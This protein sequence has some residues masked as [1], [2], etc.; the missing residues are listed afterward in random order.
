MTPWWRDAV[1]Y[2]IS[3]RSFAEARRAKLALMRH[4]VLLRGINVGAHNRIAMP[5][6]RELLERAG[7]DEVQTYLQSGNVVLSSSATG[8]Q[9]A[10]TCER[11]IAD[12]LGL[13]I[14]VVVRTRAQL[15]K[16]VERNPFREVATDP[17][18]Y[19]VSFLSARPA[20]AVLEKLEQV[21]AEDERLAVIGREIYAWHPGGAARSKL[22]A[23]L[24]G[25]SLKVTATA[26][27]WTTVTKLLELASA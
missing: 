10:R 20:P 27:N 18:R 5:A 19:Q 24:A 8:E 4:V 13:R 23:M 6:L 15:A 17:K 2:Q 11:L 14:A 16:V 25:P 1:L 9:V 7:F 3:V 12:E 26:R 22:W 21:R